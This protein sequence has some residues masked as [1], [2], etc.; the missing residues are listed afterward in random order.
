MKKR[1]TYTILVSI[2]ALATGLLIYLL[3]RPQGA[4]FVEL[5]GLG[6]YIPAVPTWFVGSLPDGL[7]MFSLTLI[8]LTIW[9]LR[10][11]HQSTPWLAATAICGL[12]FE[13]LQLSSIVPGVFDPIDIWA[14]AVG[15]VLA[16]CFVRNGDVFRH[17]Y[18]A[19]SQPKV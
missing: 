19:F 11:S 2:M 5:T 4:F 1:S 6:T 17:P 15:F 13:I 18:P 9:G 7:W 10:L 14:T 3:Y 8:V 12:G 16:L